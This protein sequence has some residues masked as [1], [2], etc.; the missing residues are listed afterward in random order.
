MLAGTIGCEAAPLAPDNR[1]GRP[2]FTPI[3]GGNRFCHPLV[4]RHEFMACDRLG[5]FG[6][7]G[8]G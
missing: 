3:L 8:V 2:S 4:T 5:W 6:C 7:L 1:S